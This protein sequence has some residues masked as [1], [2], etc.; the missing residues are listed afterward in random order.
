MLLFYRCDKSYLIYELRKA[1]IPR[2]C[3]LNIHIRPLIVFSLGGSMKITFCTAEF[4]EF[5]KP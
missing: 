1:F 4:A 5:L 3:K 2:C